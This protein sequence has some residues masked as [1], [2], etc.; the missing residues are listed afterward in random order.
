MLRNKIH[1]FKRCRV[2]IIL[3]SVFLMASITVTDQNYASAAGNI[4]NIAQY[5]I[6][7]GDTLYIIARKYGTTV[8]NLKSTNNL[9]SDM[10]YPGQVLVIPSKPLETILTEKQI[11]RYSAKFEV[12]VNKTNRVLTLYANGVP[13]KSYH[14][15][16][17]DGG[18]ADKQIAGDHKTPE[19]TFYVCEKSVLSPADKYLGSRWMRLSYPNKEDA[20][21]GLNQG[22][23]SRQTYDSIVSAIN[24]GKIPP[25]RTA[26][27]GGIGIHGGSTPELGKDWTWG[28]VGLRNR[29]V[30][31]FY[32][33]IKV[34]T[35][36]TIQK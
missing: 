33:Y 23:I 17:G 29:D 22:L 24:N 16:L 21:R 35:K 27:G 2:L 19:G 36:V 18:T 6:Q 9:G 14:V 28:C 1:V 5:T 11:D 20:G 26:L 32:N 13:L 30:E 10:I 31:E 8:A 4:S 3:F 25:Q 7:K 34:G 12:S 15:E